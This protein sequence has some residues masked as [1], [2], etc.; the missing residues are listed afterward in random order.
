ML[1]ERCADNNLRDSAAEKHQLFQRTSVAVHRSKADMVL[2]RVP[3]R[4]LEPV[5]LRFCPDKPPFTT[6]KRL[7]DDISEES[8]LSEEKPLCFVD[9]GRKSVD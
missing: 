9:V 7:R 5:N 8:P 6:S 1:A 2:S 3:I 4:E